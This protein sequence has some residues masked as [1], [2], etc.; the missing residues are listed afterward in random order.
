MAYEIRYL[1]LAVQDL[2]GIAA[3]LTGF[4][5]GSAG[6]VLSELEC[7]IARLRD[8]PRMYEIYQPDPS[9]RRLPVSRYLVFYRVNEQTRTVEIHR[10]LRASWDLPHFLD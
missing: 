1:P 3:Y 4:Y 5:P 10:I 9:Y 8:T 6:R 7:K 2:D